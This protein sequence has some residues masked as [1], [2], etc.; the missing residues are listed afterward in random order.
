MML[1]A[2]A[3]QADVALFPFLDRFALALAAVQGF[4]LVAL[5]QG[6]VIAHWLVRPWC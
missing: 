5:Q 1:A 4:D 6:A 2:C 3:R